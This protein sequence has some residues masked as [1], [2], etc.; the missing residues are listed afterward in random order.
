MNR[1]RSASSYLAS[2]WE[3][4]SPVLLLYLAELGATVAVMGI[5]GVVTGAGSLDADAL[6]SVCPQVPL[7][8]SACGY[9]LALFALRPLV[10]HDELRFGASLG[11][12]LLSAGLKRRNPVQ[13]TASSRVSPG[14]WSVKQVLLY[15][16]AVTVGA[17]LWSE[18]LLR[19]PLTRLFPGYAA[20][21][22][23]VFDGQ[24]PLLMFLAYV[25]LGPAAEEL[26]FRCCVYRRLRALCSVK[27]A[28]VLSSLLFGLWHG[29]MIQFL[30][31]SV[32]GLMLAFGYEKSGRIRVCIA[33][34]MCA[35]LLAAV[36]TIL[37]RPFPDI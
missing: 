36:I 32:L 16:A 2:V 33:A 4:I 1:Q 14:P 13:Y 3:I 20:Q 12:F 9:A 5:A 21:A 29:N 15:V 10:R 17:F 26:V 37:V 27:A 7:I 25:L 31:A 35:N 30:Y 18:L 24:F 23:G 19:S 8:S 6:L 22:G 11:T 28:A 34:H